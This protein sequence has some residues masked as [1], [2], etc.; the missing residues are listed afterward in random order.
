MISNDKLLGAISRHDRK[1]PKRRRFGTDSKK[2]SLRLSWHLKG[3]M[4]KLIVQAQDQLSWQKFIKTFSRKICIRSEAIEAWKTRGG[5]SRIN[6]KGIPLRALFF[7][8]F[9]L[10]SLKALTEH[11]KTITNVRIQNVTERITTLDKAAFFSNFERAYT[12]FN[13]IVCFV[14]WKHES[15]CLQTKF[16]LFCSVS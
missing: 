9:T 8:F 5:W 2:F 4:I 12:G 3:L 11:G 7:C 6:W 16:S 15:R 13:C 14:A 1:S 10:S